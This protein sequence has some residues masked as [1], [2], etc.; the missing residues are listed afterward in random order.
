MHAYNS[1]K[2]SGF[3]AGA[4]IV[5]LILVLGALWSLLATGAPDAAMQGQAWLI[6][7]GF[8][9]GII[10]MVG[11]YA[12]GGVVIDPG[13]YNED[14]VKAGVIASMVWAIAGLLVGVVI[15]AQLAVP[16]LNIEDWGFASFGRLRPLHTSA[17]IFAFGGNVLIATSFYVVQRTCRTRLVGGIWPW[18]VFWGYQ[19]FIVIAATGYLAGITQGKEYAEPEWYADI[20]LTLV[21]VAYLLISLCP[22]S[23]KMEH[24]SV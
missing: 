17:V 5:G 12:G 10:M 22:S 4:F 19:F 15:A 3:D 8:L 11:R 7:A 16:M 20:W 23:D 24:V 2:R 9:V 1:L 21:W 13:E 6:L 18:F 14:V